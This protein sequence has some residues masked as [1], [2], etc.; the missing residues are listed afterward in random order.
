MVNTNF[1]GLGR[2]FTEAILPAVGMAISS[3]SVPLWERGG[4]VY[5]ATKAVVRTFT[6]ALQKEIAR[7]RVMMLILGR[8]RRSFPLSGC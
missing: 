6:E 5:C 3:T 7:V 1:V 8:L 2:K 4:S